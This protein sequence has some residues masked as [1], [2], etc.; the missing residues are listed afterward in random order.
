MPAL[1]HSR[2]DVPD[3]R[4]PVVIALSE[5]GIL[6]RLVWVAAVELNGRDIGTFENDGDGSATCFVPCDNSSYSAEDF[7]RF[8]STCTRDGSPLSAEHVME[9]L[10]EEYD[11]AVM[12]RDVKGHTG[13]CARQVC[14][15][16]TLGYAEVDQR[17]H[18]HAERVELAR[19][20]A[21]RPTHTGTAVTWEVWTGEVWQPLP[22]PPY[23]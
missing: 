4:H 8:T 3:E 6:R 20:L 9:L 7:A 15:G 10:V 2:L 11:T 18:T 1:P 14:G 21:P 12:V 5:L 13:T 23:D 22:I 19:H 16:R 17:P